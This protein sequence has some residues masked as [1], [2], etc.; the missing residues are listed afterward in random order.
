MSL[1]FADASIDTQYGT[2]RS[3]WYYKENTVYYEFTIPAGVTAHLTLPSG[4]TETLTEGPYYYA[5]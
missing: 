2:I 5:E 1:G 3:H 4:K